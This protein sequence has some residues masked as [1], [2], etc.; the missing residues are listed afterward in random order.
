MILGLTGAIG[1]GKSAVL[2]EFSKRNWKTVD[3]DKLCHAVYENA[4]E[5]FV[6]KLKEFFGDACVDV[7]GYID[8]S[9]IAK[10]V[11]CDKDLLKKLEA[12]VIPEFEKNFFQFVSDCKKDN[13]NA[14]CEIPLLFESGYQKYFDAVIGI[15]TPEKLRH[16]RLKIFR[17]MSDDDIKSREQNQLSAEKKIELADYC[18][19]ND[20]TVDDIGRQIDLL[21]KDII[22][23]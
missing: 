18:I 7:N 19:V 16:D 17:N 6:S 15:W 9:V 4:A 20:G 11:F 2:A 5:D 8:R 14:V 22:R 12:L 1:S 3:A 21:L 13:I 10:A 23:Q